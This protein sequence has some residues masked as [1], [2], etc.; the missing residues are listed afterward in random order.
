[1]NGI[2]NPLKKG[3]ILNG[4]SWVNFISTSFYA[5]N[6][7]IT[8]IISSENSSF[9]IYSEVLQ[10]IKSNISYDVIANAEPSELASHVSTISVNITA[11]EGKANYLLHNVQNCFRTYSTALIEFKIMNSS[12][13][14][15]ADFILPYSEWN[16]YFSLN[17][18][19]MFSGHRYVENYS[20]NVSMFNVL[21]YCSDHAI[22]PLVVF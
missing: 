4:N 3:I 2:I 9:F 12:V 6:S 17:P 14:S 11:L 16:F 10:R 18:D 19:E 22:I 15:I 13:K 5:G 21:L 1:M 7:W 8:P 20:V